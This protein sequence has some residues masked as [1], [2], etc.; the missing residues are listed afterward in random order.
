MSDPL[1]QG[2]GESEAAIRQQ[3]RQAAVMADRNPPKP[4][5]RKPDPEPHTHTVRVGAKVDR[6]SRMHWDLDRD[7]GTTPPRIG[8]SQP[9]QGVTHDPV[10]VS[11]KRLLERPRFKYGRVKK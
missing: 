3:V 7:H 5:T 11:A 10:M 6:D 8:F 4:G 9:S 1:T 2:R